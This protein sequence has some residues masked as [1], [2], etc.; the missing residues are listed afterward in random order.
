MES[1]AVLTYFKVFGRAESIRLALA[2]FG[3]EFTE[4][5]IKHIF[6]DGEEGLKEWNEKKKDF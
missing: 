4:V 2:H 3:I 6:T 1:K 5:E